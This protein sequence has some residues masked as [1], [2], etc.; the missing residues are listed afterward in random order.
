MRT[1]YINN[2]NILKDM[3]IIYTLKYKIE[4]NKSPNKKEET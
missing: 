1:S 3:N 2:S 4:T